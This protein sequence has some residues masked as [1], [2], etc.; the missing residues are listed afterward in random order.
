MDITFVW[1]ADIAAAASGEIAVMVEA[2]VVEGAFADDFFSPTLE[3]A[4]ITF[5]GL[6][7]LEAAVMLLEA[8]GAPAA[9]VTWWTW[10]PPA[11][12]SMPVSSASVLRNNKMS[13]C[14]N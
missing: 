10:N 5:A 1:L 8:S 6:P 12:L 14:Q 11:G 7:A 13:H 9:G 4:T 3:G 2:P